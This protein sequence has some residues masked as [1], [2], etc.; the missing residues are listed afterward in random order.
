[1]TRLIEMNVNNGPVTVGCIQVRGVASSSS[2][3]IGDTESYSLYSYFDTPAESVIIG[4][5]VPLPELE[6]E[7]EEE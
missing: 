6:E 4:P 1:M 3:L 7:E 2:M 5:F